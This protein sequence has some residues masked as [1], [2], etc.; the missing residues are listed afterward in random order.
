METVAVVGLKDGQILGEDIIVGDKIAIKKGTK[1]DPFVKKK[2]EAFHLVTVNIMEDEDFATTYYEKV[3]A[4]KAFRQFSEDYKLQREAFKVAVDSFI[5]KKVPFRLDDLKAIANRLCPDS[6]LGK[7]LFAYLNQM[8][9]SENDMSY[10]HQLN[11]A[12]ICKVMA[13][14]YKLSPQET[15]LLVYCGFLYDIGKFMLPY[16]IVWKPGKLSKMEF[17]LIKTHAFHG[18]YLLSKFRFNL[19]EHILNATLQHHERCDGSGYPQELTADQIDPYAKIIAIADVYEAMTSAKTYREPLCPYQA[20]QIIQGDSFLKYD[21]YFITTFL[22]H[23]VDELIGNQV[24]LSN[25]MEG[26]VLMNNPNDF[27]RPVVKCGDQIFDLMQNR[28][29]SITEII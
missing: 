21:T 12:L 11:V 29:V 14:W 5:Y 1:I 7:T 24:R 13:R 9:P 18:Y 4:S 23:I 2:I 6:L 19:D 16:D 15:D 27:S 10:S 28:S 26:E 8:K 3:R 17:D 22:Q 20:I 25:G